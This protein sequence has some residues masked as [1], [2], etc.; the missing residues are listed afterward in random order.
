MVLPKIDTVDLA[1][2][3]AIVSGQKV[4]MTK[5]LERKL[6]SKDSRILP[7]RYLS[8][9]AS[10]IKMLEACAKELGKTKG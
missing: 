5:N 7:R 9:S 10:K 2:L 1:F 3:K 6:H 8:R 4:H